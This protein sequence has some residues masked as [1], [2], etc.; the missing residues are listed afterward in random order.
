MDDV[1]PAALWLTYAE[2]G[3]ERS[4]TPRSD[5]RDVVWEAIRDAVNALLENALFRACT[6]FYRG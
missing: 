3:D 6:A 4:V 5:S 2:L 1:S